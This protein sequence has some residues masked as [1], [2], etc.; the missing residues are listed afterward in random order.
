MKLTNRLYEYANREYI[1][2][3][4]PGHKGKLDVSAAILDVTELE[5]T[6]NL[7]AP[8]GVIAESQKE[9]AA[10]LGCSEVIFLPNGATSGNLGVFFSLFKEGDKVLVDRNCHISVINALVVSGV[11]PIFTEICFKDELPLPVTADGVEEMLCRVPDVKGVF[12]TSPNNYGMLAD[13]ACIA[14][15]VHGFNLPLIVDEAHGTHLYYTSMGEKGA[16]NC[17]ADV[18]ILSLHKNLP[19]LTQCGSIA[20]NDKCFDV[21][22]EGVKYFTST[23]PSY[24]LMSTMD[25]LSQKMASGGAELLT[26]ITQY[27]LQIREKIKRI[28]HLSL[29]ETEFYDPTRIVVTLDGC[30]PEIL[31]RYLKENYKIVC[32]M[33]ERSYI[34]FIVTL[35]N[36]KQELDI[37]YHALWKASQLFGSQQSCRAEPILPYRCEME[38]SPRQAYLAPKE[39]IHLSEAVGCVAAENLICFPP[40]VPICVMGEKMTEATIE[41]IRK[42]AGRE[43]VLAVK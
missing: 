12:I 25:Q 14:K 22:K 38:M 2:F 32:E 34:V 29:V 40:S 6:D 9:L 43:T 23:S 18:G 21:I 16:L 11:T 19:V 17:G 13:V 27:T 20:Y 28:P 24:V 4:T 3:H 35:H 31:A 5:E 30:N 8:S 37:L 7:F 42:F 26:Q 33:T 41:N 10:S 15:V 36:T 39:K 1:S